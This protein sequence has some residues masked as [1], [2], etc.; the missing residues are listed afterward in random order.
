MARP[1]DLAAE[2]TDLAMNGALTA[3]RRHYLQA[4]E[5]ESRLRTAQNWS[6]A[7]ALRLRQ[8]GEE[9]VVVP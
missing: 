9:D 6:D 1:I 3:V 7:S 4:D 2:M 8:K 5:R